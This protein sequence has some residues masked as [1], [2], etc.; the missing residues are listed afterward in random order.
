MKYLKKVYVFIGIFSLVLGGGVFLYDFY[1]T[2]AD[3]FRE[4]EQ[5]INQ[6]LLSTI[7]SC[8]LKLQE[9]SQQVKRKPFP[10]R[11]KNYFILAFN[12]D[13]K[14]SYW[15]DFVFF[16]SQENIL[17]KDL[18]L[19]FLYQEKEKYFYVIPFIK[20]KEEIL[21]GFIPLAILYPIKNEH[22]IPYFF[23]GRFSNSLLNQVTQI[24]KKKYQSGISYYGKN[25]DFLLSLRMPD[26]EPLRIYYK[27]L[28]LIFCSVG[29]VFL[30]LYWIL[31]RPIPNWKYELVFTISILIFRG[32]LIYQHL[33]YTYVQI[34]LFSSQILAINE[35]NPSLGDLFV[36]FILIAFI[37][38]RWYKWFMNQTWNLNWSLSVII[39]V[40]I[41][42]SLLTYG[43]FFLFFLLF[44]LII[45]N[46]LVYFEFTDIFEINLNSGLLVFNQSLALLILFFIF[47]AITQFSIASLQNIHF[48]FKYLVIYLVYI[49]I[50]FYVFLTI[51]HDFFDIYHVFTLFFFL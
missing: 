10:L 12:K 41:F 35:W 51:E 17:K 19:P 30:V 25:H 15:S 24:S 16:P 3:Y 37:V 14:L 26:A 20:P 49:I 34:P 46:S 40:H 23:T 2:D 43:L 11:E 6:D 33:P 28:V 7:Q 32:I 29:L 45:E 50:I 13:K 39:I 36:N 38:Y 9:L 1:K 27:I 42:L 31:L 48:K 21:L 8:E 18:S 4:Y 5:K 22:L 44:R 47:D